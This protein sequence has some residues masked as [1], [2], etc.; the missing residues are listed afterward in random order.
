MTNDEWTARDRAA[1]DPAA[2]EA[3]RLHQFRGPLPLRKK[4]GQGLTPL[5][6]LPAGFFTADTRIFALLD[7]AC[8][9]GLPELLRAEDLPHKSLFSGKLADSAE[10]AAPYL[11]ELH[12][13]SN[14]LRA[15]LSDRE[16]RSTGPGAFW[17]AQAGIFLA[18]R[19]TLDA[20]RQHLRR[21]LRVLD[22]DGAAYFF[23]FWQPACAEAY[24]AGL[25]DRPA[26]AARWFYPHDRTG[27][28]EALWFPVR[29][30]TGA[31]YLTQCLPGPALAHL[32]PEGGNFRLD[33][34]DIA[35][36]RRMQWQRDVARLADR[37]RAAWPDKIAA[38]PA[39]AAQFCEPVMRRMIA[40]GFAHLDMLYLFCVW[41]AHFGP[42]FE[43]RDPS[44][45]LARLLDP[46]AGPAEWRFARIRGTMTELEAE[47]A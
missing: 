4:I 18:T 37:L 12:P 38:D 35:I 36:F 17:A 23:R 7:A 33:R 13:H 20:L 43:T 3:L 32:A 44:G 21:F 22:P 40:L 24:F 28:I 5:D 31:D 41:E 26:R 6:A 16:D 11:V 25:A 10:G 45:R 14:L 47:L 19:L 29:D 46:A 9:E 27:R 39:Q 30:A 8:L 15:L 34:Q 1:E 42:A 2:P